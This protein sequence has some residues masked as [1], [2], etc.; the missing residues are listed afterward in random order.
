MFH[1][2]FPGFLPSLFAAGPSCNTKSISSTILPKNTLLSFFNASDP[3]TG[4]I[5]PRRSALRI[6]TRGAHSLPS[7]TP[8]TYPPPLLSF[9]FHWGPFTYKGGHRFVLRIERRTD[10]SDLSGRCR[11]PVQC[12]LSLPEISLLSAGDFGVIGYGV[13]AITAA[14]LL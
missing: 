8:S 14:Y 5:P 6:R 1:R 11:N 13:T 10:W 2:S 9:P 4:I 3:G 12:A 7:I